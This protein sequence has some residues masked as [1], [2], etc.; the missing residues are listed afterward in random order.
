MENLFSADK[1]DSGI[2]VLSQIHGIQVPP[3][4][5]EIQAVLRYPTTVLLNTTEADSAFKPLSPPSSF[6]HHRDH[7]SV[8][9]LLS[10]SGWGNNLAENYTRQK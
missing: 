3:S 9:L 5:N 1:E 6:F 4:K 7:K 10:E 8:Y 2:A